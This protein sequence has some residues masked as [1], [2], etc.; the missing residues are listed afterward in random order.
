M[1]ALRAARLEEASLV[2]VP[3]LASLAVV[4]LLA[5]VEAASGLGAAQLA[6]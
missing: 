5:G 6:L 3:L 2:A 4:P 1:A